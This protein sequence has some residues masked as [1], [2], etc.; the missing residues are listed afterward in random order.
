MG[1][2]PWFLRA[3]GWDYVDGVGISLMLLLI[4][5][6]TLAKISQRW[7]Y[8]IFL[9]GVVH[10]I[11]I[12]TN[13][14]WVGLFPG[15]AIYYIFI[16]HP[17]SKEKAWVIFDN[18]VFGNLALTAICALYYYSVTGNYYF[19]ENS[20][21]FA[22][23]LIHSDLL[24]KIGL[25]IYGDMH[26]YWHVLSILLSIGALQRISKLVKDDYRHA[27]T[28]ITLLFSLTYGCLVFWH[29]YTMPYLN[30]FLYS[31]F[32][33]PVI[34]LLLGALLAG[35]V[36]KVSDGL[37]NIM[38]GI[39][40]L[41]LSA[42]FL[43]VVI[44]PALEN[45]QGN[46]LLLIFFSF[47]F[48]LSISSPKKETR[49]FPILVSVSA[50]SFLVGL[51]SYVFISDPLKGRNIFAAIIDASNAV[52]S[53]YPNHRYADFRFWYREDINY[54][55][56][57]NLSALY[58]FPWGSAIGDPQADRRPPA[59][60]IFADKDPLQSGDNIVIVSSNPD[61]SEII[62]E[63]NSALT[64]RNATLELNSVEKIHEGSV[65]FTLYYTKV[66]IILNENS[67]GH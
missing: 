40:L 30:I 48:I 29:F 5:I 11:L 56:F 50:L 10:A 3:V 53:H 59:S 18:F 22:G 20:I 23:G 19:L 26:P 55:I 17:I 45:W 39:T 44:F 15:W 14:F 32:T 52:D 6:L 2:Y 51:N 16:N 25:S 64:F 13:L 63:A 42:P 65:H 66:D 41:L 27:F 38:V 1:G 57:F 58:L 21:A 36:D 35:I 4:Y 34:F 7:K 28:A 9:A 12:I 43:L 62:A 8:L 24:N 61:A 47:V 37:F 54:D 49:V 33:I 67:G 60:F 31:S 46:F